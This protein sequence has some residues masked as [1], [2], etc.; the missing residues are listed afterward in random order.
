MN[1]KLF[2]KIRNFKIKSIK[3]KLILMYLGLVFLVMIICGSYILLNV[4]SSEYARAKVQLQLYADKIIE[5]VI[6]DGKEN[7]FQVALLKVIPNSVGVQGNILD[8]TGTTI[9]ST[10]A[11]SPPY[12][13]YNDYAIISALNNIA[14]FS[15]GKKSIDSF[16]LLTEW[17][18][19]ATPVRN[20]DGQV[21]YVIYTKLDIDDMQTS[22]DHT[23]KIIM[24]SMLL[25]LF[26]STLIAYIFAKSL[27][28]PITAITTGAKKLA[29]GDLEHH[30]VVNSIDEIGQLTS[31]FN[32]MAKKLTI[33]M[34]EISGEKKRLEILLH[35]MSD[36]V[37]S[38]S[39]EGD[40][41]L[42]NSATNE[43]L[44]V[45]NFQMNFT[46]FIKAFNISSGVYIDIGIEQNSKKITFPVGSQFISSNFTPYYNNSNQIEGL[47][48]VLHDITEQ[49]K[50]DDM[51]K[52]FVANVS[53]ELRT[54]L[55]T[56]KSYSETLIAGAIE[57]S[58]I[59]LEFLDIIDNEADRMALLIKDLLQLSRFDNKQVHLDITEI[60]LNSFLDF[61]VKQ[62]K[63]HTDP[64]MQ[65][66]T[67]EPFER[68]IILYGDE[69]RITQVTKNILTNAVKYSLNRAKINV[70]ITEDNLYYKIH[71]KDTGMGISRD[72][73]PRIFERFFR[74]DKARMRSEGGTGLGLA[75]AKEIM[76]SHF[77]K[78]TVESDYGKGTTMTMW[79]LKNPPSD[80]DNGFY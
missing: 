51:R 46:E 73:L 69:D 27:T 47:M 58:E 52:E 78:L 38:Y 28:G 22:L 61:I 40:F 64:K 33:M 39:K 21:S 19:Y 1:N 10:T 50:L 17:L 31:S 20:E 76:E 29:E 55:T 4:R 66:L 18:S 7:N 71:I 75:I 79:F 60:E 43:M 74:V 24:L 48:V 32:H 14:E 15:L 53:H 54:P 41:M 72:N 8:N 70:F 9:A 67:F 2:K 49:K 5:Q 13:N 42:A 57:D 44:V 26:L 23:A 37:I 6:L 30:I 77:G 34:E 45:D 35:N 12:P 62:H 59:A 3:W 80:I 16:G 25:A 36:G 11:L 56:I 68:S 65:T 63:I